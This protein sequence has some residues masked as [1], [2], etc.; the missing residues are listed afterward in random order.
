[1]T[2]TDVK[3]DIYISPKLLTEIEEESQV[4][5]HCHMDCTEFADAARIWPSTFLIDNAT[6]IR[7]PMVYKENITLYPNWT[8]IP[9]G[10]SL[11]FTLFFKGLPK[12]CK[13]FDLIEV[14]PQPGGFECKKI[15]RNKDDVYYIL[16]G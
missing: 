11:N 12:S 4:I 16:F 2:E 8:H 9:E 13:S 14:I 6:G 10:S 7:Y 15:P 3:K 1:M 5:V